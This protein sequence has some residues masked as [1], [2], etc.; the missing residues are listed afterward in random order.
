VYPIFFS[1]LAVDTGIALKLGF[2]KLFERD[3]CD[4]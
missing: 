3:T 4:I 1:V 2:C